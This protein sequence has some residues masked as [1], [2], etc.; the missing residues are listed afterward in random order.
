VGVDEL[1]RHP[2]AWQTEPRRLRSLSVSLLFWRISMKKAFWG[3]HLVLPA[4]LELVWSTIIFPSLL[5]SVF[6]LPAPGGFEK[7]LVCDA[8]NAVVSG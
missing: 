7:G 5:L 8:W 4:G 2:G 3:R 6:F 1:A